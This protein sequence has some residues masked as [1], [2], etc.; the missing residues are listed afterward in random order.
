MR[1]RRR[2]AKFLGVQTQSEAFLEIG[3]G[4]AKGLA[5]G[6]SDDYEGGHRMTY[7]FKRLTE[8]AILPTK[9]HATDA[10]FDLF[11]DADVIIE[12][13]ETAVVPTGIAIALPEGFEAQ[14]R[15]RSGITSKTKLR[16]ALGTVDAGY[17]GEIGVIVDNIELPQ[18]DY[19]VSFAPYG[20]D[21]EMAKVQ[22]NQ[23]GVA[24]TYIIRKGDKLA[25]LIV[26]PIASPAQF[27]GQEITEVVA[28]DRGSGGFGST[29]VKQSF[30]KAVA[31]N[32]EALWRMANE[33]LA[34]D[35]PKIER[36]IEHGW[37]KLLK[38]DE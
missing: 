38:E 35:L 33:R 1:L 16:V 30:D 20:I 13:G 12:P 36:Q 26:S 11:A 34:Q 15:G 32:G 22:R 5:K 25:Q 17:N 3:E 9:A 24:G 18:E 28:S 19:G 37:A 21:G 4:V 27:S 29:G 31:R 10:G 14:V 23:H 8:T 6:L 7:G 2:I